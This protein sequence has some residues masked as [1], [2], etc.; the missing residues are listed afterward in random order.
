MACFFFEKNN[1][2]GFHMIG[3]IP[4]GRGKGIVKSITEKLINESLINNSKYCV[5]N[6]SKMGEQIYK[7]L[8]FTAFGTLKNYTI[9]K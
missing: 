9:I 5:L 8:G 7:K 2:A 4:K 6:A 1:L 3:T